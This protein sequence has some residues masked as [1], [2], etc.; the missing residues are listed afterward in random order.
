[1]ITLYGFP[2][3]NYFNMV[4]AT[5]LEKGLPFRTELVRPSQ[6]SDYRA[7]SP[8]GKVPCIETERGALCETQVI[9]E[10]LEQIAPSPALLPSDP[11]ERAKVRELMRT[12]E[13][14]IELP[15]RTCYG[16]V[17]FDG[18]VSDE[19]LE[20]AHEGL[21]KGARAVQQLARFGPY[22]AGPELTLA[23]LFGIYSLPIAS[24]VTRKLWEW[25]LIAELPGAAEWVQTM[26][27]RPSM[28]SIRSDQRAAAQ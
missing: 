22:L 13:L 15:A 24:R 11:Y 23:D 14:Y 21:R 16:P 7:R 18:K 27:A 28:Q 19:V 9:L 8:M 3:S 6:E 12:L 20:R 17:F 5:L 26:N 1:M 2:M 25:D 10:H 4:K